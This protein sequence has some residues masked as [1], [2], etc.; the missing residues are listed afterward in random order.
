MKMRLIASVAL[1]S[2]LLAACGGGSDDA[3]DPGLAT[4]QLTLL[5]TTTAGPTTSAAPTTSTTLP[6]TTTSTTPSTTVAETTTTTIDP[7]VAALVLSGEGI[8][9][10]EFGSEPEAVIS[11]LSSFLGEPTNDSGWIDPLS[12]GACPGTEIRFVDW[13]ILRLVFGDASQVIQG[14]R[15]F[16]AY[17]YGSAGEIGGAPAGLA[18]ER[19]ITS[20]SRVIDVIGAY[21]GVSINPEDEFSAPF[22][23]VNDNLRGF[24]TGVDDDST[25]TEILGGIGCSE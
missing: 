2:M 3:Q 16:F 9:S 21:P 1:A 14:R 5:P 18:T 6:P 19:G 10:A 11:Y 23:Y 15:H 12:V 4:T 22:F 24:V 20:G 8:G 25:V 13:G 17:Y 7:A